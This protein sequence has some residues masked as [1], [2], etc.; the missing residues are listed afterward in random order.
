MTKRTYRISQKSRPSSKSLKIDVLKLFY[1]HH[2]VALD[3]SV[4]EFF[5]GNLAF[6]NTETVT[7][8]L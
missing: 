1:D 4:K 2:C 8:F 6:I 7:L 3:F 5:L